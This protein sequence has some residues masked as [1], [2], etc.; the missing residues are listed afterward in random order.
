MKTIKKIYCC[1]CK[2]EVESEL[3]K[4]NMVYPHRQ[5]LKDLLFYQCPS[6][7]KFVG[8]HKGTT[9]PLGVIP[10]EEIKKIRIKI[11]SIID[12]LWK[13]KQ[14]SRT[15]IYNYISSKLGYQ[16]HTA[17]IRS[18]EEGAKILKIVKELED[19]G[20]NSKN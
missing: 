14:K 15:Q 13:G 9:I 11:H 3:V 2:K 12:P 8:T 18:L 1:E 16:Y 19:D 20:R 6:C 10:N 4:G 5:D 7:K 17:N